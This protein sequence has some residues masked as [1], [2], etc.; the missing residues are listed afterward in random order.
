MFTK[1]E[2]APQNKLENADRTWLE[3]GKIH[4]VISVNDVWEEERILRSVLGANKHPVRSANDISDMTT[5]FI[6]H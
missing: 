1:R 3:S 6:R 2:S 4:P 5:G